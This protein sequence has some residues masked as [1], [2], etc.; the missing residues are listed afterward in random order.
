MSP[1][2]RELAE[3]AVPVADNRLRAM[4]NAPIPGH[5]RNDFVAYYLEHG[6][7]EPIR[8]SAAV[9]GIGASSAKKFLKAAGVNLRKKRQCVHC[10]AWHSNMGRKTCSDDCASVRCGGLPMAQKAARVCAVREMLSRGWTHG[11]MAET[12]GMSEKAMQ[13]FCSRNRSRLA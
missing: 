7:G 2:L 11:R 12:L 1:S 3:T 6:Q 8:A 10:K 4:P 9:F 13:A 5:V